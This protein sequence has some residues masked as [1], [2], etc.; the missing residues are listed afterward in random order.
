[1][2]YCAHARC[3]E[4]GNGKVGTQRKEDMM[5]HRSDN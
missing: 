3:Y 5:S 2:S 4:A 1:M